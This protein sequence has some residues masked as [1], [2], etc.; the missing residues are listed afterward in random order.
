MVNFE[1][2]NLNCIDYILIVDRE[3]TVIYNTRLDKRLNTNVAEND[4]NL[5]INR[6]LF[7]IYPT[8]DKNYSS[9]VKSMRTG[10]IVVKKAQQFRDFQGILY[11]T[12]NI[13]IPIVRK[14]IIMG[15]VELTKDIKT[16]DNINKENN[17]MNFNSNENIDHI[18]GDDTKFT[19]EN[20]VT[21]DEKMFKVIEQA[22]VMALSKNP[23]LIYGETGTGKEVIVQS[24]I[25]H[26][27][28][29]RKKVVIQNCAALPQNLIESIL[30]GT[31]K[32]AYTGAE[33]RKGLFEQ[34]DGGIIFLD[35]LSTIPY[36]VQGKLLRVLQ[37]GTFRPVGSNIE[38]YVN[39][40]VIAAMNIDP[41]ESIE[42]EQLRKDLFYRL[43]SGIIFI[44]PL[45]ERKVDIKLFVDNYIRVYNNVYG[46][47]VKQI[48]EQVSDIFYEYNWDGNIREL[49]HIIES[50][51]SMSREDT[52]DVELLPAYMYDKV[53]KVKNEANT[54]VS[55]IKE[56]KK[57]I[58]IENLEIYKEE[59]N[60]NK[61]INEKEIELI[62]KVLKLTYNNK[63]KAAKILGIPR[64][65]LKYKIDKYNLK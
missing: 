43:S 39:V 17:N 50:M 41:L 59:Y 51:V 24:M 12:N 9:I 5:Y 48:T 60:L 30:F 52:L 58:N 36:D 25:N 57:N 26:S 54:N 13:T 31:H 15:V 42:R 38:K 8:L 56:Y 1:E 22:K 27:K 6:N 53:Y 62:K 14:G 18:M 61:I 16:V 2:F 4:K 47:N 63:T 11:I 29:S 49:K 28:V 21:N 3:F 46:K 32:G 7:E 33:N 64:Q 55:N 45:R 65:T 35:E 10:E 37:S 34:A 23:I 19:F 44:P 40:K 20:I